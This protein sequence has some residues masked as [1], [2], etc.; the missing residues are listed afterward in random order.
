MDKSKSQL[1][2]CYNACKMK[3]FYVSIVNPVL[4]FIVLVLITSLLVDASG[5]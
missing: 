3:T 5:R 1:T 4:G 2:I